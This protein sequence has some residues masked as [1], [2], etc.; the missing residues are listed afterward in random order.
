VSSPPDKEG[1]AWILNLAR[2][3]R[4]HYEISSK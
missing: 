4:P 2:Q 3:N 1:I